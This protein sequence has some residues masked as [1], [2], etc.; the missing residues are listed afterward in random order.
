MGT[1]I[2]H[3]S[4]PGYFYLFGGSRDWNS[5]DN[6]KIFGKERKFWAA[7]Y[8]FEINDFYKYNLHW[9][10]TLETNKQH[11]LSLIR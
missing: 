8:V 3:K 2:T 1:A 4:R 5:R 10:L 7:K 11:N 9:L 6:L